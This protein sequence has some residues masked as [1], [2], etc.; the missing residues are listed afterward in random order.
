[1]GQRLV[2]PVV[3][4]VA[5][6]GAVV[7]IVRLR[8]EV[9]ALRP[10]SAAGPATSPSPISTAPRTLTDEQR[11]AMLELLRSEAGPMH[12]VWFQVEQTRPEPAAFQK[13]LADVFREAGWEVDTAGSA[14]M[15]FKPGVSVLVADD[16]WPSYASTAYDALQKAGI[17]VKAARGYRSYYDEQKRDKPNWQGPALAPDQTYV[18]IVGPNPAS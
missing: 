1:M 16:E 7:Y 13:A 15:T 17:D 11:S 2:L 9:G 10:P 14:G 4:A 18:V 3:L 6:L 12:K 5:L 8:S